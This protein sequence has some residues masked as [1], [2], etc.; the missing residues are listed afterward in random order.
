MHGI[1]AIKRQ[2]E[3]AEKVAGRSGV[4]IDRIAYCRFG[5]AGSGGGD[6]VG[7]DDGS[8]SGAVKYLKISPRPELA[9]ARR[10]A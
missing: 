1:N 9:A 3:F 5:G 7:G 8:V 10:A 4:G 2:L 6:E